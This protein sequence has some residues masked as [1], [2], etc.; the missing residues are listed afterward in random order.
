MTSSCNVGCSC[1]D[2][3]YDP[4]C[5]ANNLQYFSPCH[6]G[7]QDYVIT[8][9][10]VVRNQT[11]ILNF[12]RILKSMLVISGLF[13][14]QLYVVKQ[15]VRVWCAGRKWSMSGSA[16]HC[17]HRLQCPHLLR[18]DWPLHVGSH[19]YLGPVQVSQKRANSY[20]VNFS[21]NNLE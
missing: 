7:C 13:Q 2:L 17:A 19:E 8:D 3:P 1:A 10:G 4:V 12:V 14:L 18:H 20:R 6:A 16:L 5:D 15:H 9:E 21:L 11:I